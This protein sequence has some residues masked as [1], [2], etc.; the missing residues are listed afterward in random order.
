[1]HWPP[2]LPPRACRSGPRA[3][4]SLRQG[5]ISWCS[6][7]QPLQAPHTLTPDQGVTPG[8][9]KSRPARDPLQPHRAPR[10]GAHAPQGGTVLPILP[11]PRQPQASLSRPGRGGLG[12]GPLQQAA[13][14]PTPRGNAFQMRP[15]R[16]G[17]AGAL[18]RLL[19]A[20]RYCGVPEPAPGP[21]TWEGGEE[22]PLP[23]PA[24][25][26]TP[27][28]TQAGPGRGAPR[29][30]AGRQPLRCGP[31]GPQPQCPV[32]DRQGVSPLLLLRH[33]GAASNTPWCP[34][35]SQERVML[36]EVARLPPGPDRLPEGPASLL[37]IRMRLAGQ[38]RPRPHVGLLPH[39]GPELGRTTGWG[40]LSA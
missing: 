9:G 8:S 3:R 2:W 1:M 23:R 30:P 18:L 11:R 19:E 37:R 25:A 7:P 17:A 4:L 39:I 31:G 29:P 40:V 38:P 26:C 5:I 6:V 36:L 28:T 32:C 12:E 35:S 34:G 27:E 15:V 21:W 20:V 16:R 22:R 14:P 33:S 10:G 24:R 13:V